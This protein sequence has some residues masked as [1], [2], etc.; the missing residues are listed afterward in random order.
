MPNET[1][2]FTLN[3]ASAGS[4]TTNANGVATLQNVSLAGIGGGSYPTGVA[5]SFAGDSGNNYVASSGSNA[6]T[7]SKIAQAIS[8]STHAPA[9]ASNADQFTVAATGGG[10]G[11]PVI[12]GSSGSCSNVGATFTMTG[13]GSC[14]VTYDQAGNAG[15]S[16]APQLTDT[17]NGHANNQTIQITTDAPPSAGYGTGF[18]VAATGGGSGNPIVYGS[19]GVCTNAGANFTMT[20]SVGTCTVTYDQAGNA[21]YNAAPQKT[22][23]VTATKAGQTIQITTAAP[24]TAGYGTGFTVAATGGGSG[25]AIVVRLVGRM[26]ECR[27][28]LHD[29]E[30]HRNMHRH[31]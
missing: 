18:T 28:G 7:I 4:A 29:D 23:S 25:N 21:N 15:Y 20:G 9:N 14:T 6:L 24:A 1:V 11:N 26:H 31:L 12:Y 5:A 3:G 16:A 27:R 13:S 30:R 2:S 8:I 22:E 19:S 17:V 10:S